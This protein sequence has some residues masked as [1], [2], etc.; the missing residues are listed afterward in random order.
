MKT[1]S[2]VSVPENLGVGRTDRDVKVW[3]TV[4]SECAHVLTAR[5]PAPKAGALTALH[6]IKHLP[7]FTPNL[8]TCFGGNVSFAQFIKE[9]KYLTNVT[10]ATIEWYQQSF[11]WLCTESP[12][13][14]DL[15]DFVIRMRVK[16]LKAT[17]CNNRIRAVNAYLHWKSR[18]PDSK[19]GAGCSHLRVPKLKE[20][21]CVLP[22]FSQAQVTIILRHKPNG[23]Y[24]RRLWLIVLT[25]LDTGCRI[26]EVLGVRVQDVDLDNLLLTVTGKGQKQR[27]VPFSFELRKHLCK[28]LTHGLVFGTLHGRALDRHVIA[29]DVKLL[30]KKLG[31]TPPE[32]TLHAFRHTFAVNY[33]RRGGSVFHLQKVLGH[34]TLEM[35]RRYANLMTDDLQEIHQRVSL[36]A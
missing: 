1:V 23:F 35:T 14:A 22:T 5:T 30:C 27:K 18:G 25:L 15:R 2:L 17:A 31:F 8:H 4:A 10:P 32:R 24:E 6:K 36:L 20:P 11:A 29:R 3:N 16:G 33:I 28:G 19:C 12:T 9:R 13:D 21:Q 7:T 34:S 26:S